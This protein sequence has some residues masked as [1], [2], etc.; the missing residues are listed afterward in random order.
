[1]LNGLAS[2]NG[3]VG[4]TCHLPVTSCTCC[5]HRILGTDEWTNQ[6]NLPP[7]SAKMHFQHVP[8]TGHRWIEKNVQ[9]GALQRQVA[10]PHSQIVKHLTRA[11]TVPWLNQGW[12]CVTLQLYPESCP[13]WNKKRFLGEHE[14][15]PESLHKAAQ[16]ESSQKISQGIQNIRIPWDVRTWCAYKCAQSGAYSEHV[17]YY[18]SNHSFIVLL[19]Q[20]TKKHTFPIFRHQPSD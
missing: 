13:S 6:C 15:W 20:R 3:Q 16:P 9:R 1:M 4:A 11:F 12:L 5:V 10:P 17:A 19:S 18:M 8:I 14:T 2:V 7:S